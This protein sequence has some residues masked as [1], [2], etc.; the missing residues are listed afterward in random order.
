MFIGASY[1]DLGCYRDT[2][3]RDLSKSEITFP[4]GALTVAECVSECVLTGWPYV[5]LQEGKKCFCGTS[6]GKHGRAVNL[7]NI[8]RFWLGLFPFNSVYL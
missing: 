3:D 7:G 4:E 6:Y 1:D 2:A 5:G 8:G